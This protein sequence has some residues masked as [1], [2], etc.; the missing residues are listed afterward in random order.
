MKW[1][2]VTSW[3]LGACLLVFGATIG[4]RMMTPSAE[5]P[6]DDGWPYYGH[7]AGG[8]R[9]SPLTQI[10][11][12][13]VGRLRAAWTYDSGDAFNEQMSAGENA[14]QREADYIVFAANHA[15]ESLFEFGGFVG[16]G[17]GGLERH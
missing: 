13:N 7:D 10:N 1:I 15:A 2:R 4:A 6:H 3:M 17:A 9:Y 16:Y 8:M 14:D 12:E 11:P 5:S